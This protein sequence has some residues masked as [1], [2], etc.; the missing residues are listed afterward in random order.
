METHASPGSLP[1]KTKIATLFMGFKKDPWFHNIII[2]TSRV[3]FRTTWHV[4]NQA[5]RTL[6]GRHDGRCQSSHDTEDRVTWGRPQRSYVRS[7]AHGNSLTM[8]G[9]TECL[10]KEAEE[11]K[12]R[13]RPFQS[14]KYS[15]KRNKNHT[16]WAECERAGEGGFEGT[17]SE[18][19]GSKQWGERVGTQIQTYRLFTLPRHLL[20]SP[21]GS[22]STE[23]QLCLK[24][25]CLKYIPNSVKES[26]N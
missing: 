2:S 9:K 3:Q 21:Q 1:A 4:T 17:S 7:K 11:M 16:G 14:L 5:N 26:G 15:K 13:K 23:R 24:I 19:I 8:R 12:G 22:G 10:S 20:L 6:P 18:M 25:Q